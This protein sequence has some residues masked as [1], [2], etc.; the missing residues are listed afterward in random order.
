MDCSTADEIITEQFQRFTAC[1]TD[2]YTNIP[3]PSPSNEDEVVP[4]IKV[5]VYHPMWSTVRFP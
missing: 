2:Y 1:F 5:S 4:K 3:S